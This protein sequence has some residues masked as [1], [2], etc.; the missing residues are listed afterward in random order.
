[1]AKH[2][3]EKQL[4]E[5]LCQALETEIGGIQV[6]EHAIA[7]AINDD[8]RNEFNEYLAQ[9]KRHREVLLSVCKQLGLD[10]KTQTPG[11]QVVA[12]LGESLVKAIQLARN[13]G[14]PVAAELVA[15]ECVVIAET[16]DHLNWELI[17][18]VGKNLTGTTAQVLMRAYEEIE[19]Q[20]D[21]HLYHSKGWAR[22]LWID[23]LGLPAVLPPPED[24][25]RVETAI[26]AARAEQGREGMLKKG[27]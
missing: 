23:S 7:C 6:Y 15:C 13:G 9:T 16:K 20:E 11:R 3:D 24:V 1:M 21:Q 17:G 22:E 25:K 8:L 26:A 4:N 10:P 14:D 19:D 18:Q 12:H 2:V 5:L 27:H